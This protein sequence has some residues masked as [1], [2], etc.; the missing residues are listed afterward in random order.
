MPVKR[1]KIDEGPVV[2]VMVP[3]VDGNWLSGV[4]RKTLPE[5]ERDYRRF[6]A[7]V[8]KDE[9]QLTDASSDV[10]DGLDDVFAQE[11]LLQGDGGLSFTTDYRYNV[12]TALARLSMT[13]PT[14]GSD[15]SILVKGLV[16]E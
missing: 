10:S 15:L 16:V 9:G 6:Y 1:P 8:Y 7:I 13:V 5:V 14:S 11:G 2:P 12:G 4:V 3:A